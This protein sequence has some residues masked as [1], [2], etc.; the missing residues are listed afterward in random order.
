MASPTPSSG[1]REDNVNDGGPTYHKSV[2]KAQPFI[3]DE[4]DDTAIASSP[5][6]SV[7][8]DDINSSGAPAR[9]THP[10]TTPL[11]VEIETGARQ[12]HQSSSDETNTLSRSSKSARPEKPGA[13]DTM[14]SSHH[15]G[16]DE[17]EGAPPKKRGLGDSVLQTPVEATT[18]GRKRQKVSL[19]TNDATRKSGDQAEN[20]SLPTNTDPDSNLDYTQTDECVAYKT[21]I[22]HR[23]NDI[24]DHES[25]FIPESQ[26]ASNQ[27]KGTRPPSPPRDISANPTDSPGHHGSASHAGDDQDVAEIESTTKCDDYPSTYAPASPRADSVPSELQLCYA[28]QRLEQRERAKYARRGIAD[29]LNYTIQERREQDAAR[30]RDRQRKLEAQQENRAPKIDKFTYYPIPKWNLDDEADVTF[31]LKHLDQDIRRMRTDPFHLNPTNGEES[32]YLWQAIELWEMLNKKIAQFQA[33]KELQRQREQALLQQQEA[34]AT[35]RGKEFIERRDR[36]MDNLKKDRQAHEKYLQSL[37]A[38]APAKR[39]LPTA[40]PAVEREDKLDV[41]LRSKMD[42]ET[43][44]TKPSVHL[45]SAASIEKGIAKCNEE[46]KLMQDDI[47]HVRWGSQP[48]YSPK[49]TQ[50]KACRASLVQAREELA[51]GRQAPKTGLRGKGT[52]GN[53]G[54]RGRQRG[55]GRGGKNGDRGRA[56]DQGNNSQ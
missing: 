19:S 53:N 45:N 56:G 38:E 34:E 12:N 21:S 46:M 9:Q 22:E 14:I 18:P 39:P 33:Q 51:K 32:N 10:P 50:A 25:L 55:R 16:D 43:P 37:P 15:L 48:L 26:P 11:A 4:D 52:S 8:Q 28:R 2:L 17:S 13:S 47:R 30:Q 42:N 20:S 54:K 41:R 5:P 23:L 29:P 6:S 3:E 40:L 35:R 44:F 7:L 31:H 27:S 49:Y 36:R 1:L 24:D